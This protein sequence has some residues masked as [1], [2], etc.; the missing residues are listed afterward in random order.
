MTPDIQ[1]RTGEALTYGGTGTTLVAWASLNNVAAVI[2]VIAAFI[3]VYVQIT[4]A[5]RRKRQE[6]EMHNAR[7][8]LLDM[9]IDNG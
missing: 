2:G 8:K 9:E 5:R 1:E 4:T 3:G 6:T 7:M